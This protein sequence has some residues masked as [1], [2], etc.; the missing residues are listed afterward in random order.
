MFDWFNN[1]R[2][3][4]KILFGYGILLLFMLLVGVVVF[5]Q[6]GALD[7]AR[8]ELERVEN[9]QTHT[10]EMR[11][12]LAE[13]VAA[14]RE[15]V[16]TGSEASLQS[17]HGAEARFEDQVRA[18]RTGMNDPR[19][20]ARL[21]TALTLAQA[22]NEEVAQPGIEIVRGVQAGD[23][24]EDSIAAFFTA[25]GRRASERAQ[26][27]IGRL[28]ER[29]RE[30]AT[31]EHRSMRDSLN[32]MQTASV[33]LT[34]L[35]LIVTL[36]VALWI[37]SRIS[38][39]LTEAVQFAEAVAAGDLTGQM[40]SP[41]SDEIGRLVNALNGM[42]VKLRDLVGE[43]NQAT[44]QVASAAE[45][46][47]ATSAHISGT[48]DDQVGA[49]ES[50]SSSME[51]IASQIARVA[52]NAEGLAASVDQTSSSIAQMGQAIQATAE[53]ADGL[54]SAVD[55]TSTTMEEMAVSIS[56][57]ERHAEETRDIADAAVADATAGGA[58]V[59]QV[60]SGMQRIHAEMEAL[61]R[62]IQELGQAGESVGTISEVMEDIA[63]Q[64]NLLALN[65]SIEAARAGEHG[66]GFAVVAQEV[67]RL[68][69]RSVESARDIRMTI[70][71][72]RE[73]VREAVEST[74]MVADR[75]EEG[76]EVVGRAGEVLQRIVESS[77][78][79]RDLMD[80]VAVATRQQTQAAEQTRQAMRNIQ[81]IAEESR[82]STREQAQSS[83]QI[84][85]AVESM[86]R[87][88]QDVFAATTEQKRGGELILKSTEEISDGARE[89]QAAV[90]Q[91]VKAAQD[92]SSQASRLT[93]LI[94][95]FRV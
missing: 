35:A 88:T 40:R 87:Q 17:L 93:G 71:S 94:R 33:L 6:G 23:L 92:L 62:T 27:A 58:A 59:D 77:T 14:F 29:A 20:L 85:D 73:R 48:V 43:V 50:M 28:D 69:E 56:H 70:D 63:D 46:I 49:T 34:L 3:R 82:L 47:A 84:V 61:V 67:R 21:D 90:Q 36:T 79:T 26:A 32:Q 45:E 15:F 64:T 31:Q 66:R 39:P 68:A 78:R 51:E 53:N 95:T 65:A 9:M 44:T 86:N 37:A 54:G 7:G 55:E 10:A 16:I 57:A 75:T 11:V 4:N 74:A 76:L 72:V 18:V 81:Q 8:G 80:E 24:P 83:E 22:W 60:D 52:E 41:G 38:G 13:R 2:V 42:G 19:Q 25:D 1:T 12:A 5:V 30:V 91:L 89:A